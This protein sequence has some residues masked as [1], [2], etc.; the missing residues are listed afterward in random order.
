MT[1]HYRPGEIIIKEGEEPDGFYILQTGELDIIKKGEKI[2][3]ITEENVI[4]GE[5]SNILK[6]HRTCSVV[7]KTSSY[8]IHIPKTMDDIV[9]KHPEIAKKIIYMLAKRLAETTEILS[10]LRLKQK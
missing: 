6:E 8:V 9:L 4:F 7:A 5:L 3:N 10:K 2:A 1:R